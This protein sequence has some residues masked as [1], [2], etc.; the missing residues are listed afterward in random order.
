MII[1]ELWRAGRS[2]KLLGHIA[3]PTVAQVPVMVIDK[4]KVW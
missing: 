2:E 3:A 4:F 1:F